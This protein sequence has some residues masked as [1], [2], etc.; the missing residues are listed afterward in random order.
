MP[1]VDELAR[2]VLASINTDENALAAAK[3]I[4]NRYRE[5]V[6][7]VKFRHLRKVGELSL[8]AIIETGT[9][10]ATRDSDDIA[11]TSTAF[12]TA[13][14]AGAQEHY[15]FRTRTAWYQIESVTDESNIILISNFAEDDVADGAYKIAKRTHPL[16]ATVRWVGDFYHT[17]LRRG[18]QSLSLDELNIISP[19]RSLIGNIPQYAAQVGLDSTGAYL[20]YE[21]Y[22]PPDESEILH[23]IYWTLPGTLAINSTIPP[24]IDPYV[25]KEGVL[26]DLY[27]L[28]KSKEIR[29]GNIEQAAFWRNEEKAQLV[30]WERAIKD[31]IRTSRGADDITVILDWFRSRAESTGEQRTARDYILDNWSR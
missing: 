8:P 2:D 27:R 24:V 17:R 21:I 18:L 13:M 29:K 5:M 6:S 15:Y 1:T 22:P 16:P 20:L 3:W 9:I 30:I 26:I 11:G 12:Q 14:G 10:D 23:Y 28:E 4:D 25:L 7:K 31:A 19:G